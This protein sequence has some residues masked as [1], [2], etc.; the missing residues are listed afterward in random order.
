MCSSSQPASESTRW[1][2]ISPLRPGETAAPTTSVAPLA[3]ASSSSSNSSRTSSRRPLVEMTS[4]PALR[5]A[6]AGPAWRPPAASTTTSAVRSASTTSWGTATRRNRSATTP[7]P[8]TATRV[9]AGRQSSRS[10]IGCQP[11]CWGGVPPRPRTRSAPAINPAIDKATS[12]RRSSFTTAEYGSR[13]RRPGG[14]AGAARGARP[15]STGDGVARRLGVHLPPHLVEQSQPGH[16]RRPPGVVR[17]V[18][19]HRFDRVPRQAEVAGPAQVQRQLGLPAGGGEHRARQERA[20]LDRQPLV[21]PHVA[22]QVAHRVAH[23][24]GGEWTG[25]WRTPEEAARELPAV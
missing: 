3:R 9:I 4:M 12:A 23:H 17:D 20:L 2:A 11:P 1:R 15:P 5:L 8:T 13:R 25:A 19:Q 7:R 24:L 10:S 16:T 22:E 21:L 18:D 14:A 6:T